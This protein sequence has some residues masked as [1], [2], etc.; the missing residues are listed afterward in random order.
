[1]VMG[2]GS[3]GVLNWVLLCRGASASDPLFLEIKGARPSCWRPGA[4][5]HRGREVAEATQRLQTWADPFLG[6][7]TLRGQ[8][9]LMR[10]W[11]DHKASIEPA[12]LAGPG[13]TEYGALCGMV[14]A[15]AQARTGDPARLAGYAGRGDKLDLALAAFAKTY[16]GQAEADWKA[17][18][19]AIGRGDLEA[20]DA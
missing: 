15:K 8:P 4:A 18:K 20:V 5:E 16:A 14:L 17:F 2:C 11:S 10:Q 3:I 12:M 13:L 7:T 6:W 9:C 19:A 1:R